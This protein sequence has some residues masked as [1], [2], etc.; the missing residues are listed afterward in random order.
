M[1]KFKSSEICRA[2]FE[3]CKVNS[4]RYKK[5]D[6]LSD[7]K[8]GS[9]CHWFCEDNNLTEEWRKFVDEYTA[10]YR[11]CPFY[12]EYMDAEY[13]CNL[14]MIASGMITDKLIIPDKSERFRLIECC[15][16]CRYKL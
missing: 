14:Q 9:Y 8:I 6:E 2:F 16:E 11:Y 3:K 7:N 10:D 5:I 1:K 12:N 4:Y 15:N 13:C